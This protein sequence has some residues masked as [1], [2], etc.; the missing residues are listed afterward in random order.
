M[1][2]Q[3]QASSLGEANAYPLHCCKLT[4]RLGA[5]AVVQIQGRLLLSPWRRLHAQQRLLCTGGCTASA[6]AEV[7]ECR[8]HSEAVSLCQPHPGAH[9][10]AVSNCRT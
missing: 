1:Y 8:Q 5:S 6:G 4:C 10:Q 9:M 3:Q 2:S 7:V